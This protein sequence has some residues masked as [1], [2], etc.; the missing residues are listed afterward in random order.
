MAGR[1]T[2][3][4]EGF[5]E[6]GEP[7]LRFVQIYIMSKFINS[8]CLVDPGLIRVDLPWMHIKQI[9]FFFLQDRLNAPSKKKERHHSE[10]S[11]P[12]PWEDTLP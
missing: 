3:M 2:A 7:G 10:I 9:V 8:G 1:E 12:S 6:F 11:A 4:I 5:H